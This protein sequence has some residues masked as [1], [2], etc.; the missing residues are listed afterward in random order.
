MYEG[1]QEKGIG[2]NMAKVRFQGMG[3]HFL[4]KR[5]TEIKK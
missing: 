1:I 2:M 4:N 3:T 5:Q